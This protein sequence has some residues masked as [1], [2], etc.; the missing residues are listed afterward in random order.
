MMCRR[1][2]YRE[3]DS[4][5]PGSHLLRTD[6]ADLVV[7]VRPVAP[8]DLQVPG[9]QSNLETP[10]DLVCLD[11]LVGLANPVHLVHPQGLRGLADPLDLECPVA[12]EY[13]EDQEL[14]EC[15]LL[16]QPVS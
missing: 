12:P 11:G 1:R 5:Y 3:P 7:H 2:T 13:P 15:Y 9:D 16:H 6:P 8:E 10:G 4:V 14:I